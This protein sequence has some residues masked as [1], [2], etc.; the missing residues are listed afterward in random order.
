[1][2]N[3]LAEVNWLEAPEAVDELPPIV[4]AKAYGFA[5]Y[6]KQLKDNPGKWF[7]IADGNA[8]GNDMRQLANEWTEFE[9]ATRMNPKSFLEVPETAQHARNKD[10]YARYMGLEWYLEQVKE[11]QRKRREA[12]E[13]GVKIGRPKKAEEEPTEENTRPDRPTPAVIG[14][15]LTPR[16]EVV[17]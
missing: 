1:M 12:A 15:T 2:P 4:S 10:M 17:R 13:K 8:N 11:K 7:K 3:K 14:V 6:V 16:R 5:Q 9:F